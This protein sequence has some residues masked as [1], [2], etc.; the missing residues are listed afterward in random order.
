LEKTAARLFL[1]ECL[2]QAMANALTVLGISAPEQMN[3]RE[4]E[5]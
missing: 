4:L 3:A 5:D 2:R 1:C